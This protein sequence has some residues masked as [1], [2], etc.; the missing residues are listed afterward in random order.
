MN[1]LSG[2]V[3]LEVSVRFMRQSYCKG[4]VYFRRGK[5]DLPLL[6]FA[7]LLVQCTPPSEV[8][9]DEKKKFYTPQHDIDII[10]DGLLNNG[11]RTKDKVM[12]LWPEKMFQEE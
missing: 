11:D 2:N 6:C 8:Q 7:C 5:S 1:I 3:L 10:R 9:E 12:F 4:S